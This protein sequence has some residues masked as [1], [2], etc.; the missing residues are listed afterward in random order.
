MGKFGTCPVYKEVLLCVSYVTET[1]CGKFDIG[2]GLK[3]DTMCYLFYW[4]VD[5]PVNKADTLC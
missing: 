4:F 2:Q 5:W 1:V 3:S